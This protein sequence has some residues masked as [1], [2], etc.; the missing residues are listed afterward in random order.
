LGESIALD[1]HSLSS[2][3]LGYNEFGFKEF[4]TIRSEIGKLVYRLKY[5]NDK[6]VIDS[7]VKKIIKCFKNENLFNAIVPIPPSD[8]TRAYQPVYLVAE[9]LAKELT[10]P[11]YQDVLEKTNSEALKNVT[12][13]TERIKKLKDCMKITGKYSLQ[14]NSVLLI[15]DLYRSGST[16]EVATELLIR[17][18]KVKHVFV[19]A[20]TKTRSNR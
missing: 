16:L 12:E 19:L 13:P 9:A 7:I 4:D 18:A 17:E 3:F 10:L 6:T 14:G 15:D 20:L 8:K 1:L 11:Y 2:T 5:N